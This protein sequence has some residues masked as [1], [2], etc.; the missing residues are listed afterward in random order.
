MVTLVLNLASAK[1]PLLM[2]LAFKLVIAEPSPCKFVATRVPLTVIVVPDSTTIELTIFCAASNFANRPAVPL[3]VI[4]LLVP[5]SSLL[6]INC[7]EL[8]VVKFPPLENVVQFSPES[9]RP[10]KIGLELVLI[11]CGVVIVSVPAPALT[12]MRF[13]VPC[14]CTLPDKLLSELTFGSPAVTSA[15]VTLPPVVLITKL[16]LAEEMP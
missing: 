11:S 15:I 16:S 10:E 13:G 12:A 4:E 5:L 9:L 6:Q 7:P 1:V 8:L 2:L 14:N 3:P